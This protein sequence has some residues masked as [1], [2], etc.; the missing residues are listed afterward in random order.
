MRNKLT[1]HDAL[2]FLLER[3]V[4]RVGVELTC[5]LV[6]NDFRVTGSPRSCPGDRKETCRLILLDHNI[7][8]S[9]VQFLSFERTHSVAAEW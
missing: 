1:P 5:R 8:Q 6:R 3:G 7:P 9:E 4:F 2:D